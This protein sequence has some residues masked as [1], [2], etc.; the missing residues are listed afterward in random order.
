MNE[1]KLS[2]FEHLDELRSRLIASLIA[3]VVGMVVAFYLYEPFI[4]KLLTGPLDALAGRTDNP[5]VS[6]LLTGLL[7]TV[8]GQAATGQQV[9]LYT[10][11][12]GGFMVQIKTAFF[13]G[14]ILASPF[15]FY[16]IWAFVAAG[17]TDREKRAVRIYLPASLALFLAGITLAY[18]IMLPPVMYFFLV[19]CN[20]GLESIPTVNEYVSILAG[21][22]LGFGLVFQMPILILFLTHIGVVT[23]AFLAK[24]RRYAILLIFIVAAI[25]TPTPDMVS[26]FIMAIPMLILY[27]VSIWI[28]RAV[29][30]SRQKA[31]AL[32]ESAPEEEEESTDHA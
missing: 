30:A 29:F 3:T 2:F 31:A 9:K 17:L 16:Q 1:K 20:A 22:C 8:S 10:G 21:C 12:T 18:W 13:G 6:G 23:P 5:F 19:V 26:Q 14:L 28:S 32:L 11:L 24:K 27:E 25:F 7:K 4:F 15:I